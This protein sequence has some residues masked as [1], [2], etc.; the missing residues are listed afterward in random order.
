MES[1]YTQAE[2]GRKE[3]YGSSEYTP[4]QANDEAYRRYAAIRA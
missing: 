1:W 4:K 2:M 3:E